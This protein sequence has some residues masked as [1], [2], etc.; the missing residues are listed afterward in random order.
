MYD[1]ESDLGFFVSCKKRE[2]C[3]NPGCNCYENGDDNE[4]LFNSK[5]YKL[6]DLNNFI[7]DIL[8]FKD[9]PYHKNIDKFGIIPQDEIDKNIILKWLGNNLDECMIC[10]EHNTVRTICCDKSVCRVCYEKITRC[11]NCRKDFE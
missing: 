9:V 8:K 11:P 3:K 2:C 1:R 10:Y 5:G 4:C 6:N 7:N